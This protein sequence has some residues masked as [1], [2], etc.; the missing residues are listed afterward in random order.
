MFD[1]DSQI[2]VTTQHA[3]A[4]AKKLGDHGILAWDGDFYAVTAVQ[5]LGLVDQGGLVRLGLAPYHTLAEIDR[6]V[7]AVRTISRLG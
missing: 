1:L 6:T 2:T 3:D 4:V 5:S 7:D